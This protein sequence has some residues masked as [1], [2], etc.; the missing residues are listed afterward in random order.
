MQ[1]D[2]LPTAAGREQ[3][4][5]LAPLDLQTAAVAAAEAL[6]AALVAMAAQGLSS[7]AMKSPKPNT[8]RRSDE[9]HF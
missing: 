5:A 6:T 2:L 4:A 9:S 8:M 3:L 7:F 1:P